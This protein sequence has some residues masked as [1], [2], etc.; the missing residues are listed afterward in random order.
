[1]FM[2][3]ENMLLLITAGTFILGWLVG[4]VGAAMKA[5][6]LWSAE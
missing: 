6:H 1:M 4:R 3:T 5:R 2:D